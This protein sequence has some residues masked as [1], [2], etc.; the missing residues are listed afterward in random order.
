MKKHYLF[1]ATLLVVAAVSVA[2][3]SCKKEKQE[4]SS[5][6]NTER[7]VQSADNMDEYLI[8][9]KKKLL[10]A[11]KGEE[12]ISLEQ[13]QRDLGNLLNFDFGDAN[14]PTDVYQYD[15]INLKLAISDDQVDLSQ[16]ANTYNEAVASILN[17]YQGIDLP[18]KSVYAISCQ[19]LEN[20]I[21]NDD[22]ENVEIVL[23]TRGLNNTYMPHD[24]LDWRPKNRAGTCDGQF[25][26]QKGGPE[27]MASWLVNTYEPTEC[28][29]GGRLY[30][31]DQ[32]YWYTFGY[33][34]YDTVNDCFMI[35]T[36]FDPNQNDCCISHEEMEY[37][38]SNILYLFHQQV[39]I[40]HRFTFI[41]IK[42]V[43][44]INC[45]IPIYNE[46][47]ECFC[48]YVKI[49]HGKPNCTD[50]NPIY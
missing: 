8:S 37:Y 47:R 32:G 46:M 19:F 23:I 15:T 38:Y 21:R 39:P 30:Y 1:L 29:N 24:T 5:S 50:T 49:G 25:I 2:V 31:T 35:Y 45:Y 14:Y 28:L 42:H 22:T 7:A 48:W 13:A 10:S 36:S 18:E 43:N 3:V 26:N 16:L 6:N 20:E 9:F 33:Q 4:P 44:L 11:Q 27:V 41:S 40:N 12:Y 17:I 34:H